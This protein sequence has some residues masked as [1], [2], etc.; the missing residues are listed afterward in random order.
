MNASDDLDKVVRSALH[1]LSAIE[2]RLA[3]TGLSPKEAERNVGLCLIDT[4]SAWSLFVRSFFISCYF[5]AK[6][7]GGGRVTTTRPAPHMPADSIRWASLRL[8]PTLAT[9][10][11]P[12]GP[13]DE[14]RWHMPWVLPRLAQ[15][16]G[17]SNLPQV[18]VAFAVPGHALDDLPKARI[19]YAHRSHHTAIS[20]KSLIPK[21]GLPAN[22]R[23]GEIP[24]HPH[25]ARPGSV[26]EY[27]V[28]QIIAMVRLLPA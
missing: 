20:L 22:I 10:R 25:P 14:P 18:H 24:G 4:Q 1:Q 12:I 17:F 15:D 23:A 13:L 27:W 3:R 28:A 16:A 7:G 5:G 21:Y 8:N 2:A 19:F 26:A 11:R 9:R 6:R